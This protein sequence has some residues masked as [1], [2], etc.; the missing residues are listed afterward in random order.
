[1]N[2]YTKSRFHYRQKNLFVPNIIILMM[3]LIILKPSKLFCQITEKLTNLNT[4]WTTVLTGTPVSPPV[5]TSYGFCVITDAKTISAFSQD[6]ILIWEKPV[7]KSKNISLTCIYEDFLLISDFQNQTI[8]LLNPTG[9]Q[10]W[11]KNQDDSSFWQVLSGKDGRFFIIQKDKIIC[12]GING[13]Q[14]WQINLEQPVKQSLQPN[15]LPDSSFVAFLQE[16]NGKT[17]GLRLSPYGNIIEE[18]TFAGNISKSFSSKN[19]IFLLFND[20]TT[21]LFSLENGYATNK[22]AVKTDSSMQTFYLLTDLSVESEFHYS[23]TE[24]K[25]KDK[26]NYEL[27]TEQTDS[28]LQF[29]KKHDNTL[30]INFIS[31]NNG[32][33]QKKIE[34]KLINPNKTD[35]IEI[36]NQNI[37]IS[38]NLS[39]IVFS[40]KGQLIYNAQNPQNK[41]ILYKLYTNS[42][43]L[44]LFY[45]DWSIDSY[46]LF[47]K[48]KLTSQNSVS[49]KNQS[50]NNQKNNSIPY[51]SFLDITDNQF[52][53]QFSQNFSGE[54]TNSERIEKLENGNYAENEKNWLSQIISISN[55]YKKVQSQSNFG[56]RTEP[57]IFQNDTKGFESI[58]TQLLLFSNRETQNLAAD[59]L[60]KETNKSFIM[61]ILFGICKNGYDPEQK[62]LEALEKLS[63]R[64]TS[65]DTILINLICDSVYS[66]CFFQGRPAYNSKGK[67]ILKTFMFPQYSSTNR[68]YARNTLKKI[69]ELD[70]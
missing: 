68:D 52:D 70:L 32:K 31:Q 11:S 66:I 23:P 63:Q 45:D 4:S 44:I 20:N 39:T 36:Q 8:T 67:Q 49:S 29:Q 26:K 43:Y 56:T 30:V 12:Y 48:Q 17:K 51:A 40:P 27:Q 3:V 33:I 58:L 54:I 53:V 41:K 64:V 19:G 22:W 7:K 65:K 34:T 35:L 13:I 25:G 59:I 46:H 55:Q 50:S 9:L 6:G 47:S 62:L 21:G 15:T 61:T 69:L 10:I 57:S 14:K 2:F 38:D 28:L 60:N 1:M 24:N 37:L 16:V 42:N 5:S 18:I